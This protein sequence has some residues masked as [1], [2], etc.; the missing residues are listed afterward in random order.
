MCVSVSVYVGLVCRVQK[1]QAAAAASATTKRKMIFP[2]MI[3][4][5]SFRM[6]V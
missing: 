1:R 5:I 2:Q 4:S 6:R 3:S